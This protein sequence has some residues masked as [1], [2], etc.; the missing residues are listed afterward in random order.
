MRSIALRE[1]GFKCIAAPDLRS[2]HDEDVDRRNKRGH[3][4]ASIRHQRP[5]QLRIVE[6]IISLRANT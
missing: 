2:A 6:R 3:D 5:S 4:D 1:I